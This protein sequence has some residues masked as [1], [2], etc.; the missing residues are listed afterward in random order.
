MAQIPPGYQ[1]ACSVL[2]AERAAFF[3]NTDTDLPGNRSPLLRQDDLTPQFGYVGRGYTST[4]VLLL[5]INPGNGKGTTTTR[6]A[7]DERMMPRLIQFARDPSPENFE[8]AQGA[9]HGDC[10][11]WHIWRRHCAE[12]TGAGRLSLDDIAYSN[13]LPWRTGSESSFDDAVAERAA[14]L[15]AHPL[16]KE[17]DPLVLICLGKR[18]AEIVRIGRPPLPRLITWNRA[19]AATPGVLAERK[20][21]AVEVFTLLGCHRKRA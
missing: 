10:A 14:K 15:Y 1:T 6:T 8:L 3:C 13:C 7:T 11:T 16:I 19:Q 4:G 17:L 21:A 5:G 18:A 20:R 9:Y 12:I 2:E